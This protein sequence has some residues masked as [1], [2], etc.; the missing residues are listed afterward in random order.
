M[1]TAK[2]PETID[3]K[4]SLKFYKE[5]RDL[6]LLSL[7]IA[8][9]VLLNEIFMEIPRWILLIIIGVVGIMTLTWHRK[10]KSWEKEHGDEKTEFLR[11]PHCKYHI[12]FRIS[13][14]SKDVFGPEDEDFFKENLSSSSKIKNLN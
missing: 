11:C 10:I 14:N 1:I 5:C 4:H 8:V 3:G 13:Q 7:F 12:E 2:K 6:G 9:S